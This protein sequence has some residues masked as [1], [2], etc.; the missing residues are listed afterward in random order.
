MGT[1][2]ATGGLPWLYREDGSVAVASPAKLT[3]EFDG[4]TGV[5]GG[6]QDRDR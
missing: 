5:R 2:I 3:S 6:G 1:Q 4:R